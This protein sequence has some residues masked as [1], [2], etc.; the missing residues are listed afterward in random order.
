MINAAKGHSEGI[1][2]YLHRKMST[3]YT[4]IL[5]YSLYRAYFEDPRNGDERPWDFDH[6]NVFTASIAKRWNM[7][8]ADWYQNMRKKLW[9]KVFAFFIPFGDEVLLSTKWRFTGGRPY[10]EPVYLR[11]YHSWILPEDAI[12]NDKTYADYHRFD[13][14]LDRRYF[15][16]N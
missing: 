10:T 1:E 7:V 15:Y 14:R 5:S 16:R 8:Q 13:V 6:K 2:F 9:Y 4:Y 3:S 12:Q 11:E